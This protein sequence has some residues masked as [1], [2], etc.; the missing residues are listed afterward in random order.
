MPYQHPQDPRRPWTWCPKCEAWYEDEREYFAR[1]PI[2]AEGTCNHA[3]ERRLTDEEITAASQPADV[4]A[5]NRQHAQ[6]FR[7]L[8]SALEAGTR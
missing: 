3:G 6:E 4:I 5:V 2:I 7:A 8:Q 1:F